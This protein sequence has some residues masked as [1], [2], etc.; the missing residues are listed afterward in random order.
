MSKTISVKPNKDADPVSY[1]YPMPE[2]LDDL[3][4]AFGEEVVYNN[5]TANMVVGL[6]SFIRGLHNA[7]EPKS[8]EEIAEAVANWKPGTRKPAMSKV[9]KAT[10][11]FASLTDEEKAAALASLQDA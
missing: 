7:E 4:E 5:A 9:E 2:N 11:L 6:Q 8:A 10:E 1:E 3:S